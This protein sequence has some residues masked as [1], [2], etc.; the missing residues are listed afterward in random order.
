MQIWRAFKFWCFKAFRGFD[1]PTAPQLDQ[2]TIEFLKS[3]LSNA[4][5]YLEF[6]SGGSTILAD[7]MRVPTISVEG[8]RYYANA[9][10]KGLI[11]GKVT[12][13]TPNIGP[14][15]QWGY[16]HLRRPKWLAQKLWRR[17]IEAPFNGEAFPDLILVDGR[18]RVACAL[19]SARRAY[20]QGATST[21]IFDD[22]ASRGLYHTVEA[23][24]GSPDMVGRAAV[25]QIGSC[26]VP[27]PELI[28]VE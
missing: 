18:F 16:P 26:D 2:P 5:L 20:M 24:L 11:N 13:V 21:L 23:H 7:R 1:T 14:T 10:R 4:R 9:V 19:E 6:G 28:G 22:Y 3:K 17:Y 15:S 8:D 12:L 27:R 25:F